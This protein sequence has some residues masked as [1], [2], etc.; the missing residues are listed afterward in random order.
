MRASDIESKLEVASSSTIILGFF[1][2]T[3]AIATL[4]LSPPLNRWPLSPLVD[5][6]N[7][8]VCFRG[9][10]S[11]DYP[12][13]NSVISIRQRRNELMQIGIPRCL[14]QFFFGGIRL[15]IHDVGTNGIVEQE[16]V[17]RHHTHHISHTL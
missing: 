17:L 6:K 14:D 15:G 8:K 12:T 4:C 5:E 2:N 1:R 16:C 13:N 3:R 9:E 11:G 10:N 7:E